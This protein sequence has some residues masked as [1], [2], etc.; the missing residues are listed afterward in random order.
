MSI[1][2]QKVAKIWNKKPW[3]ILNNFLNSF[4]NVFKK[5]ITGFTEF[6][7]KQKKPLT[8]LSY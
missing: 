1:W 6:S 5:K 3:E 7:F 4:K 2:H 8:A